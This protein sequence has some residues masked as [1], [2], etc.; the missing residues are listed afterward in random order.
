M[1]LAFPHLTPGV[2]SSSISACNTPAHGLFTIGSVRPRNEYRR[3]IDWAVERAKHLGM[4]K[5]AFA[6][7]MLVS[8]QDVTNWLARG[9]PPEH[10][11]QAAEV[12]RCT[13]DELVG[14]APQRAEPA[15]WPFTEVTRDRLRLLSPSDRLHL[16]AA[17][18][19][20]IDRLESAK[21]EKNL[22]AERRAAHNAKPQAN[23]KAST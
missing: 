23:R 1:R 7:A 11:Q 17:M 9:M 13:I 21:R 2:Y 16:E 3:P 15:G 18:L 14:R 22:R 20:E 4:N 8:P 6:K 10:H 5:S 19:E 12:L